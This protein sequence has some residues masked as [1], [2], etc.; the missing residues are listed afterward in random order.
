LLRQYQVELAKA[1]SI[2]GAAEDD[3]GQPLKGVSVTPNA[4]MGID[5][6]GYNLVG[7]PQATTD[8]GGRFVLAGLASGYTQL[9]A[10]L[11]GYCFSD[12]TVHAVPGKDIVLRLAR[13]GAVA[14]SVADA[15][16]RAIAKWQGHPLLIE[17]EPKGGAKVGTWGGSAQVKEDGR[18][19]FRD[20]PPG[21]YRLWA[22]PNPSSSDRQY[23]PEQLVRVEP[24]G[25]AEVRFVFGDSPTPVVKL[26]L[27]A[28]AGQ[29]GPGFTEMAVEGSNQRINVGGEVLLTNDAIRSAAP[30]RADGG[31]WLIEI[32]FTE[33]GATQF[34]EITDAF[35]GRPLAIL[36]DGKLLAA[37]VVRERIESGKA[38]ITG[39]FTEAE[40]KRVAAGL[41][42]GR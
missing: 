28:T 13:A 37:P 20:V 14:V 41:V 42:G 7:R 32:G 33:A 8:E 31:T 5:G 23:A 35:V 11:P 4:S 1:A 21:E 15:E 30:R 17:A 34:A 3:A 25:Q 10:R 38:V 39:T 36:V 27:R 9:R 22:H 12:F 19:E 2:E 40:A 6:R 29:P 26:E 24:G 16:G 18:Y